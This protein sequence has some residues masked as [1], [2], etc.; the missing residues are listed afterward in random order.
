MLNTP[1]DEWPDLA[2]FVGDQIYAD[3]SSPRAAERIEARRQRRPDA[4]HPPDAV[5]EDFEEYMK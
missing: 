4:D 2:I 5:V 3:D 1:P